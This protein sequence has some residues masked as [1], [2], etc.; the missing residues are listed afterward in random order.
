M[1]SYN[2]FPTNKYATHYVKL[3]E[4]RKFQPKEQ[5]KTEKH[6][7]FPVSIFGKIHLL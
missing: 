6:H 5:F 7:I 4:T 2:D 1:H 3:M